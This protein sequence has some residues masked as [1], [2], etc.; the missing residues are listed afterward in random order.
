MGVHKRILEGN[1][2]AVEFCSTP[3]Y[4]NLLAAASYTLI[5]GPTPTRVGGVYLF[6]LGDGDYNLQE[7]QRIETSGVFDI[8]W[9]KP[10]ADLVPCLGQAS[11]DGSLRLYTLQD[12]D[13]PTLQETANLDIDSSMCLSLD[14]SPIESEPQIAISHS[15][16]T[17]TIVDVGQSE[18]QV[19][20]SG[21]AHELETW[22]TSYDSWNP[23]VIYT[24]A[25]DC[26]FCAWDTRQGLHTAVFR[27]KKTHSMGVCS[28]QT[29]PQSEHSLITG[30]Y[31]ENLRLWD[32]RMG[33]RPV[34]K[35]ETGLGGG[36]WRLK[37]HPLDR[38]LILAACMH[39][40]FV[41]VRVDGEAMEVVEKYEGHESLA[42]GADWYQG[43]WCNSEPE[44]PEENAGKN[45]V[46]SLA[47]TCSFYDKAL[48]VW[49]PSVL[50]SNTRI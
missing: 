46:R 1:A 21:A 36:V 15:N 11:A 9:R 5:E 26:Q 34:M 31:D 18:P 42:Y 22:I 2:D 43:A 8:K 20:D 39:N 41:L 17:L 44:K 23:N 32:M 24:G 49:E 35:L 25:D 38:G 37:W 33:I 16:G 6:T 7:L 12:D 14:W 50:A 28:I 19:C 40:G 27:N 47:A 3:A 4:Y 30:S 10:S 48:H 13:K 45:S 29:N